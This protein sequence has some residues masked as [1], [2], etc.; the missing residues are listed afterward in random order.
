MRNFNDTIGNRTR[1]L[2]ACSSV[3]QTTAPPRKKK[4]SGMKLLFFVPK[5][6]LFFS[7]YLL[8]AIQFVQ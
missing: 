5:E 4:E 8:F 2:P 7:V 3:P 6:Q 1:D